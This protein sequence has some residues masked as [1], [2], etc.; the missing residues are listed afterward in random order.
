MPSTSETTHPNTPHVSKLKTIQMIPCLVRPIKNLWTQNEPTPIRGNSSA[1]NPMLF[2]S[3]SRVILLMIFSAPFKRTLLYGSQPRPQS[4]IQITDETGT[5]LSTL[6]LS[7]PYRTSPERA[8]TVK[9]PVLFA[10]TGRMEVQ[11]GAFVRLTPLE[12]H[13][14]RSRRLEPN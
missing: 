4:T 6:S 3:K 7:A 8:R 2:R 13:R 9:S 14:G 11:T 1:T 10:L 12:T 5:G